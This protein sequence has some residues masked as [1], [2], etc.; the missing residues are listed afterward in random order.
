MIYVP[1]SLFVT[2]WFQDIYYYL[3]EAIS[4]IYEGVFGFAG[5]S[6]ET[7]GVSL[8]SG[9]YMLVTGVEPFTFSK[10]YAGFV[11]VFL[12]LIFYSIAKRLGA[13][14]PSIAPMAFFSI[15][16]Q[17]E[18]H[19]CRLSFSIMLYL[20]LL[21]LF[22]P[23]FKDSGLKETSQA[24]LVASLP[25]ISVLILAHPATPLVVVAGLMVAIV[26]WKISAPILKVHDATT[27]VRKNFGKIIVL[28]IAWLAW[29][30]SVPETG[31]ISILV[32][33]AARV[34]DA[35]INPLNTPASTSLKLSSATYG[36][37][38]YTIILMR[39]GHWIVIFSIGILILLIYRF[40]RNFT[41]LFISSLFLISQF[42]VL[43]VYFSGLSF[44]SRPSLYTYLIFSIIVIFA[45]SQNSLD[46]LAGINPRK[47]S[48]LNLL[49]T[50]FLIFSTLSLPILHYSDLPFLY[51]PSQEHATWIY[52]IK[53]LPGDVPFM[54]T[55]YNSPGTFYY[56]Q[57]QRESVLSLG[58]SIIGASDWRVVLSNET[59]L[60]AKL[61]NAAVLLLGSSSKRD[62][63]WNVS[64]S[65]SDSL[66][67]LG[68]YL[69]R[70]HSKVYDVKENYNLF[71]P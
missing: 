6:L 57:F 67:N 69:Q 27:M 34:V 59:E 68:V 29:N 13:S 41:A 45:F 3:G 10:I 63:F 1:Y 17:D 5:H 19:V 49:I 39:I 43:P 30:V 31:G 16:W 54:S 71:V 9:T 22:I 64:P 50:S 2:P 62:G 42:L 15:C 35:L 33:L 26:F 12:T 7:P 38:Y 58:S 24:D 32:G 66:N 47:R 51:A 14:N 56:R 44:T 52:V 11:I 36:S 60:S 21:L 53:Y 28:S 8:F 4:V 25:I 61:Q 23:K 37:E 70:T 20:A 65:Y 46:G 18:L 40:H 48:T 55:S